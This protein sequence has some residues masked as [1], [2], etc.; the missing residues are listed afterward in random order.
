M[1]GPGAL[2][3][4]L[5]ADDLTGACDAAVHFALRGY[6]T[7]ASIGMRLPEDS[8]IALDAALTEIGRAHV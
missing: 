7:A 3:C 5:I 1:S 8:G 2:E 4:L 6:R